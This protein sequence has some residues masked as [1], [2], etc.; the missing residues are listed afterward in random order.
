MNIL[1]IGNSYTYYNDMPKMLESLLRENGFET[2]IDAVTKGGR[3]LYENLV[4]DDEYNAKIRELIAKKDYDVLFL[5]EQSY[6]ALVDY[7]K[8]EN[9]LS[10]LID[11][12]G[13]KRVILYATWGRKSGSPLLEEHGW[14]SLGMTDAL[15][16]AYNSAAR[17]LGTELSPVGLCFKALGERSC[18]IE[19]YNADLSHPS[20][21]G[22]AVAAICHFKKITGAL[23]DKVSSITLDGS[24]VDMIKSVVNDK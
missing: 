11:L 5:Q 19:L 17:K 9:A 13:A 22:S 8:F 4:I 24:T 20:Y 2:E 18:N 21:E 12:V 1:C 14:T 6:F 23:P 16:S 10:E 7:E 3:R 15:F